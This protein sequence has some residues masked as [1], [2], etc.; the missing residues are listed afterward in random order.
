VAGIL[1]R[2]GRLRCNAGTLG[3]FGCCIVIILYGGIMNFSSAITWN[4]QNLTPEILLAYYM[5]G[6]PMDL[7]H[8]VS[9]SVFLIL[10]A[11]PM[12]EKLE[13]VKQKYGLV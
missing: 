8:A 5:S 3:V 12:L 1:F 10:A 13:R 9:T 6:L 2:K 7:V 11:R 4:A